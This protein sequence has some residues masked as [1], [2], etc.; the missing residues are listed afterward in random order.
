MT[1]GISHTLQTGH[2]LKSLISLVLILWSWRLESCVLQTLNLYNILEIK[3]KNPC[4]VR[5]TL[6]L[7]NIC[8]LQLPRRLIYREIVLHSCFHP[9]L[10]WRDCVITS[11]LQ[12]VLLWALLVHTSSVCCLLH[13][14]CCSRNRV[15]KTYFIYRYLSEVSINTHSD[16][17]YI[18][19]AL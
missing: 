5:I 15:R 1:Y 6:I 7:S 14:A 8:K 3:S 12:E 17:C 11:C 18:L 10:C 19:V 2:N 16:K 13:R 4:N 9:R